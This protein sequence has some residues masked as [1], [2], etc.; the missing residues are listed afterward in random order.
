MFSLLRRMR[1]GTRIGMA[2]ALPTLG[3]L[4]FSG[5]GLKERLGVMHRM[6][7][8]EKIAS[9]GMDIGNAAHMLQRERGLSV[10]FVGSKGTQL[11]D[12][13]PGQRKA[14][15]DSLTTLFARVSALEASNDLPE[16]K[17][18]LANARAGLAPLAAKRAS[19]DAIA[20]EP[21][22]TAA[23]FTGAI[24]TLMNVVEQITVLDTDPRLLKAITAYTLLLEGKER[25]GQERAI[26]AAGF[27][28]Q[29]FDQPLYERFMQLVA[30]QETHFA[31]FMTYAG[32]AERTALQ[33]VLSDPIVKEVERMRRIAAESPFTGTTGGI[34]VTHWF[35]TITKKID[36]LKGF[37][38]KMTVS[39]IDL[40]RNIQHETKL[41]ALTYGSAT[42]LL[43]LLAI[44]TAAF[45]ATDLSVSLRRLT[46][47]VGQMS[48]GNLHHRLDVGARQDEI[49]ALAQGLEVF[50]AGLLRV[51][52]LAQERQAEHDAR[53]QRGQ[54]IDRMLKEFNNEVADALETITTAAS[55]LEATSQTMSATAAQT[56]GEAAA[57]T[58]TVRQMA[59]TM[60]CVAGSVGN[61]S[62]VERE[63]KTLVADSV[64]IADNARK[65][66]LQT[67]DTIQ[68][69][70]RTASRIGEVVD[71][72][73]Q[74]A[75]QTNLLA[76]N[77][78][79]EAARAGDAGKGFAVVA[80]EVKQL[81]AQTSR[82]TEE[83]TQQINTVQDR[84][85]AA[86]SAIAEISTIIEQIG[87]RSVGISTAVEDQG[88]V[89]SDIA[90]NAQQVVTNVDVV[91]SNMSSVNRAA[92]E[93]GGSAND[94]LAAARLVTQ[95][96]NLLRNQVS[97]FVSDIRA[98]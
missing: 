6:E 42:G 85:K 91:G 45:I 22:P 21:V 44:G 68:E 82:A 98:A 87:K 46:Q 23:F 35:D 48:S 80:S 18:V 51:E 3:M 61:L 96:T 78:T 41:E 25:A 54:A 59:D 76:L 84:T 57:A 58:S 24:V 2:L 14:V 72:I 49:G 16:L 70:D 60:R 47:S 37:E 63:I 65:C 38:D 93:T 95:R 79:I 97:R 83:I 40:A 28:V 86:V 75:G 50:R 32:A 55:Q 20:L 88:A 62:G 5:I 12:R 77:A 10:G 30:Q 17:Q 31:S 94:V 81:A 66:S 13:L 7:R 43:L 52:T 53:H 92:N 4:I 69:L 71:L 34:A 56:S 90:T 74:I 29:H 39:L 73:K 64:Q 67:N 33:T 26:G 11:G 9:L 36:M 89:T 8:L 27:S 15:D 1:A 19:I